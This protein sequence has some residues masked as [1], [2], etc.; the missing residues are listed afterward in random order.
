MC[1]HVHIRSVVSN[2]FTTPWTAALQGP[3]SMEFFRQEYW[4][5]LPFP[6]P[7]NLPNPGIEPV[8]PTLA[9]GFF[10]TK[11]LGSLTD[12][13]QKAK[14]REVDEHFCVSQS[15]RHV[16]NELQMRLAL[17]RKQRQVLLK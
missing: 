14:K 12:Y 10:T 7:G 6:P 13:M 2:P 15:A 16:L 8:S 1:I 4:S 5:G 11:P 9:G 3:L 17:F